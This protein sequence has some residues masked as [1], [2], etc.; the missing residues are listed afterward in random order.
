MV[1]K[2]TALSGFFGSPSPYRCIRCGFCLSAC[3]TYRLEPLEPD[4]PRG[5]L[6]LLE[7]L[8]GGTPHSPASVSHLDRCL[9]CRSCEASCPA[10][11]KAALEIHAV[12]LQNDQDFP[13]RFFRRVW[14]LG[15]RT[16]LTDNARLF[17][18]LKTLI[19]L[20][21]TLLLETLARI[22]GFAAFGGREGLAALLPSAV[23]RPA[24]R[25]L[26][27]PALKKEV[28]RVAFFTGCVMEIVLRPA[29]DAA[30]ELLRSAGCAV[31]L[32]TGQ[33]CCG[34]LSCH[35]GDTKTAAGLARRNIEAFSG[36]GPYDFLVCASAAC[37]VHL[38]EY[39]SLFPDDPAMRQKAELFAALVRD[40][41][42]IIY[43]LKPNVE[44]VF[45]VPV[46]Y[47]ESCLL[48]N[49][50]AP[51]AMGKLL[52]GLPKAEAFPAPHS[53]CC[54]SAGGYNLRHPGTALSLLD[55][56]ITALDRSGACT[57]VTDNPGCL[58]F[59]SHGL[60]RRNLSGKITV[61]HLAE[62]LKPRGV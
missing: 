23:H 50:A 36:A 25:P 51:G 46:A 61:K 58:L 15:C 37:T 19:F 3:P 45:P 41:S 9:G 34:A 55:A 12:K 27:M 57:L 11:V 22:P 35:G 44:P 31:I 29:N 1:S 40:F 5:R 59:L 18:L 62:F 21:R 8:A 30:V 20:K 14:R 56:E 54:G 13:G 28:Y 52:L 4:S 42:E 39:P 38:R 6:A 47:H 16:F 48:R 2:T 32:P 10:G 17:R 53:G 7:S 60:K 49:S 43:E 26:I 24:A 33:V